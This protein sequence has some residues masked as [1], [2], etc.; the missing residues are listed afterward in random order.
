[1][2]SD[3]LREYIEEKLEPVAGQVAFLPWLQMRVPVHVAGVDFV[4]YRDQNGEV[5]EVHRDAESSLTMI[6]SSYVDRNNEPVE[7]PVIATIPGRGWNVRDEDFEAVSWAARLLFLACLAANEYYVDGGGNY[8]NSIP[9][10][11]VWQ[12]FS[13]SPFIALTSRRRYGH[14]TNGGYKHGE[15]KF[16][17]PLQCR[18]DWTNV[19]E[20]FL[21]ALDAADASSKSKT[22]EALKTALP[23]VELANTDDD[24]MNRGASGSRSST[25]CIATACLM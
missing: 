3:E 5:N 1:M 8:I 4:P 11:P 14:S 7:C 19:D 2:N 13:G 15:V 21:K 23:Y 20:A 6:F 17:L 25:R 12:R 18:L 24:L 10:R 9:F 22:I 16:N